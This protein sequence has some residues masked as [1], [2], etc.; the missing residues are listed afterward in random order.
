MS[1]VSL[2]EQ[3]TSSVS[4][5]MLGIISA[6]ILAL[7]LVYSIACRLFFSSSKPKDISPNKDKK[8]NTKKQQGSTTSPNKKKNT[9]TKKEVVVAAAVSSSSSSTPSEE[10]ENEKAALI[11]PTKK[12]FFSWLF[13]ILKLFI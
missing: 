12:V 1:S 4:L 9:K 8:S 5:S 11:E 13:K 10:S 7:L 3:L 6:A 2:F